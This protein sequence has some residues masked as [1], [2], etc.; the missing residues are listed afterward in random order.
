MRSGDTLSGIAGRYGTTVAKLR[1]ANGLR[2]N[3]LS[4]GQRLVIPATAS[5]LDAQNDASAD[6]V[7]I[8]RSGDTLSAIAAANSTSVAELRRVNNLRSNRLSVGQELKLP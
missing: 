3:R 4:V 2:S 6:R 1:S 5:R 7:Y 8:V